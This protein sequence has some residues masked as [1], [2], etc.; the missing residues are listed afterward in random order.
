MKYYIF[1]ICYFS[2]IF[3][4]VTLLTVSVKRGSPES[5]QIRCLFDKK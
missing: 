3:K 4:E 1:F 2:E 5:I